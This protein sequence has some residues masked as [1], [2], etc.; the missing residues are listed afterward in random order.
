MREKKRRFEYEDLTPEQMEIIDWLF[1]DA[2]EDILHKGLTANDISLELS[3]N[4]LPANMT[5]EDVLTW[6]SELKNTQR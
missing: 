3:K 6:I 1:N 2:P 5:L 4:R